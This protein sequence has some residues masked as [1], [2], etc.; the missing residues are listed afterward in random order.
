[1][2]MHNE[3]GWLLLGL[4]LGSAAHWIYG[5]L[6]RRR[7][8][9]K[10]AAAAAM[11]PIQALL[12]SIDDLAWIKDTESR[13]ILVNRKFGEVFGVAP[14][15]LIGKT[16]FDLSAPEVAAVY[17]EDD[18][19]VMQS[20]EPS[21][22][23]E[24]IA[25]SLTEVGWSETIKVPVFDVAGRVIGT[26][27]VARDVTEMRRAR[28]LLEIRVE[29]RTQE[30]SDTVHRLKSAQTE[31]ITKEKM[32]ALGAMVAGIAHEL[33]TPIGTSLTVAST[34]HDHT[35]AFRAQM[36]SGLT[37]SAL[38]R[39]VE[40]AREGIDILSRSLR[41][42]SELV[43]SFKQVAVD[44]SSTHLRTFKLDQSVSE[45]VLLMGP[46]LRRSTHSITCNVP[47]DIELNSF[48]GPLGQVLT[49][50]INNALIH[51]FE[52]RTNGSIAITAQRQG[53][54]QVKLSVS[55]DGQGISDEHLQHIFDPFF[56]TKLGRGGSGLGL[57]I[58]YNL[59]VEILEGEIH[60]DSI[61]ERGTTFT[62]ILPLKVTP[63]D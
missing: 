16:D 45:I 42:A 48:P 37:R 20:K 34:L 11:L 41:K 10:D 47:K 1:M 44:Q 19:K 53:A 24:Q 35:E 60:V 8:A 49:N 43:S 12:D 25:R 3:I 59:V 61:P 14:S 33:N 17:R 9:S 55:D 30:L 36:A 2:T 54:T 56:T 4:V 28:D 52:S 62:L 22:Q 63:A 46:S 13:F 18:I 31:L 38:D 5:R 23:E 39:Y 21:R 15:A 40:S 57:S 26:A 6:T 7:S 50:L 27:G 51:A 58:V 32:A 29:E